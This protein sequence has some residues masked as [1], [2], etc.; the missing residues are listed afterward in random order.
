MVD[1][2]STDINMNGLND[3][4]GDVQAST[5]PVI[6][7]LDAATNQVV[8]QATVIDMSGQGG[9][10]DAMTF[11]DS[12]SNKDSA[13]QGGDVVMGGVPSSPKPIQNVSFSNGDDMSLVGK[14]VNHLGNNT[15]LNPGQS[16]QDTLPALKKITPVWSITQHKHRSAASVSIP[17]TI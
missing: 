4:L 13:V 10:K 11:T 17:G 3:G 9:G 7:G 16:T 1:D 12:V 2:K 15:A 8:V 5:K 6:R 14:A